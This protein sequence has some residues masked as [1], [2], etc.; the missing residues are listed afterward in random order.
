L[1]GA[2]LG[3]SPAEAASSPEKVYLRITLFIRSN[4]VVFTCGS[5]ASATV[6]KVLEKFRADRPWKL[7]S[8]PEIGVTGGFLPY[9][10][11]KY[12]VA[13]VRITIQEICKTLICQIRGQVQCGPSRFYSPHLKE[14][15]GL[16]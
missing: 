15:T 10:R 16:K 8:E 13:L 5:T 6:A 11:P 12:F 3:T 7:K 4:N 14:G 9:I 2:Y 1:F